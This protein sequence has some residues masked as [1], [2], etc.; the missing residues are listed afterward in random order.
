M[1]YMVIYDKNTYT[2]TVFYSLVAASSS[3]A[4]YL[5]KRVITLKCRLF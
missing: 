2:N 1:H 4:P 5:S 3:G